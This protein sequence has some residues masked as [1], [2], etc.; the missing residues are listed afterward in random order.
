MHAVDH[1]FCMSVGN[2]VLF[3]NRVYDLDQL[4]F[5]FVRAIYPR[6]IAVA[7]EPA[8]APKKGHNTNVVWSVSSDPQY[9]L[10]FL[11]GKRISKN[12]RKRLHREKFPTFDRR[13]SGALLELAIRGEPQ[14]R[15]KHGGRNMNL[16]KEAIEWC[17]EN[18]RGRFIP[19]RYFVFE[20]A[21]DFALA[22]LHG[23]FFIEIENITRV[24]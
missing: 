8:P 7:P 11:E 24:V 12:H 3:L 19:D 5:P 21:D 1:Q 16:R 9:H 18:L 14:G 13:K 23:K 22:L 6:E 20:H 17:M 15:K 10:D 4:W 2:D